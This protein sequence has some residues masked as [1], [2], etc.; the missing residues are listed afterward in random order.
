MSAP[1]SLSHNAPTGPCAV[2]GAEGRPCSRCRLHYY[3]GTQHQRQHWAKHRHGCGSVALRGRYVVA[4][5]DIPA[6]TIVLREIPLVIYP[7]SPKPGLPFFEKLCLGCFGVLTGRGGKVQCRR[8]GL[9][10]CSEACSKEAAHAPECHAFQRAKYRVSAAEVRGQSIVILTAVGALRTALV[11]Q[12]EPRLKNLECTLNLDAEGMLVLPE[13]KEWAEVHGAMNKTAVAWLRRTVGISWL[14]EEELLRAAL[15]NLL[16][17]DCVRDE[18]PERF[19]RA[20]LKALTL[21]S[22][23]PYS[24]LRRTAQSSP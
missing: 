7:D 10:V 23:G 4:T 14:T 24:I 11:A 22:I 16:H 13:A 18:T 15:V 2:C 6:E 21:F 20:G 1:S 5:K 9:P 12:T 17:G 3:C 8:C 19:G